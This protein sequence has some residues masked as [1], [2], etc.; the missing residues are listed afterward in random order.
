[1]PGVERVSAAMQPPL[2]GLHWT[3][4]YLVSGQPAPPAAERPWAALNMV[5]PGY[6]RTLG[7]HLMAGR[8]FAAG[9]HAHAPL[10]AIVNET[11]ARK[12]DAG[13]APIGKQVYVQ[14]DDQVCTV[15]GVVADIHQISLTAPAWPEIF[16]PLKQF[17]VSF[18]SLVVR[19]AD[20]PGPVLH[21]LAAA[22]PAVEA[23]ELMTTAV[24]RGLERLD[25]LA[26]LMGFFG[27]LALLVAALG[28]YAIT[29]QRVAAGKRD[30][31]VRMALGATPQGWREVSLA[32]PYFLSPR[33]PWSASSVRT[34]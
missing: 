10:V 34:C 25:F 18:V 30:L 8:L 12:M 20:A 26:A 3:T 7:A 21:E 9:D 14:D 28:I 19:T 29:A 22:V 1:M 31:G 5:I 15:V 32:A 6:F 24:G 16:V 33:A 13:G 17:P 4:P 11:M 23:P 2:H 27:P